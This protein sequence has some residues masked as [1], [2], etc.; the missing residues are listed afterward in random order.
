MN[1]DFEQAYRELAQNEIPD[2]W[3]R[4][5]AGISEKSTPEKEQEKNQEKKQIYFGRYAGMAAAVL[6]AVLIVPAVL[7]MG[8]WEGKGSSASGMAAD[9]GVVEES[10]E[11]A[12]CAP[13]DTEG[14]GWEEAIS[15]EEA[16]CFAKSAADTDAMQDSAAG[17]MEYAADLEQSKE[18]ALQGNEEKAEME[19]ADES[20]NGIV[21]S[22]SSQKLRELTELEDGAVLERVT[23]DVTKDVIEIDDWESVKEMGI[24]Q[25]VIVRKDES[26]FF[27]EGEKIEIFVPLY[28][29]VAVIEGATMEVDLIYRSNEEYPFMLMGMH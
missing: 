20:E 25:T 19:N 28:S 18:S 4:I 6:C 13:E 7:F 21:G 10:T 1:K 17:A 26:G 5:E 8:Q 16:D 9:Q 15:M 24:V 3:D 29:S 2:L 11:V 12:E 23:I 22:L 14:S 27:E